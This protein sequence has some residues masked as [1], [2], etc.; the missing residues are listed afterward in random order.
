[1]ED[2]S[3]HYHELQRGTLGALRRQSI[4]KSPWQSATVP[5]MASVA[6]RAVAQRW[7]SCCKALEQLPRCWLPLGRSSPQSWG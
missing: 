2:F 4:P 7:L 3:S 1:L 5:D 6:G